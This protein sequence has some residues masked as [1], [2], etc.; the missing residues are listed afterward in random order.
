MPDPRLMVCCIRSG[1]YAAEVLLQ[2]SAQ[3]VQPIN[4]LTGSVVK[5]Y[6]ESWKFETAV[7]PIFCKASSL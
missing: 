7:G 6:L 3:L 2:E 5:K 1:T 4:P